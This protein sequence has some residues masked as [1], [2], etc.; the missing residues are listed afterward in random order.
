MAAYLLH[1]GSLQPAFHSRK[2]IACSSDC[3][4]GQGHKLH[5]QRS[6]ART[7]GLIGNLVNEDKHSTRLEGLCHLRQYR[8]VNLRRQQMGNMEVEGNIIGR[9]FC[10]ERSEIIAYDVSTN[11]AYAVFH[12][13]LRNSAFAGLD[14]WLNIK[15]GSL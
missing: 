12:P 4:D 6:Q 2:W 5:H 3:G 11:K 9:A 1:T 15:N 7:V 14:T 13:H 10:K 8:G